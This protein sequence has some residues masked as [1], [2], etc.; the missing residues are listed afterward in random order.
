MANTL[1]DL[2][3]TKYRQFVIEQLQIAKINAEYRELFTDQQGMELFLKVITHPTENSTD[4]YQELEF[5]GDGILKGVLSQ[6]IP[7]RFPNLSRATKGTTEGTLSKTR[8]QLEQRETLSSIALGLGFWE[9]VLGDEHVKTTKRKETLEDVYEAFIG[10]L[11][12]IVDTRVKRGLGYNYAY[13]Y[14]TASLD[15]I[16]IDLSKEGLDDAISRLNQIYKYEN[17]KWFN[18]AYGSKQLRIPKMDYKPFD[19]KINDIIFYMQQGKNGI[20]LLYTGADWIPAFKLPL[21]NIQPYS[22]SVD[23]NWT[24]D[25][26]REHLQSIWYSWVYGFPSLIGSPAN[27]TATQAEIIK[28]PASYNA[29]V[30][31]RGLGFGKK[32]ARKQA[33]NNALEYLKNTFKIEEK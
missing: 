6:Y 22:I 11:V 5:I 18:P 24:I 27:I 3:Q 13:N 2:D 4:N 17:L 10:A 25:E 9:F 33:A 30:I 31:G 8:R 26:E 16:K 7:R 15:N 20:P 29:E 12:E 14:I 1:A 28:N 19:A 21:A 32:D 23:P